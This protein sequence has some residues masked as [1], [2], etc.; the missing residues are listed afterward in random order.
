MTAGRPETHLPDSDGERDEERK[1]DRVSVKE[2]ER[3]IG[4]NMDTLL[5][6]SENVLFIIIIMSYSNCWSSVRRSIE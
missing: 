2:R 5:T 4:V 6:M 3:G 1:R